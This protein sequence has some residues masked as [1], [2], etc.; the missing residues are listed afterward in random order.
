MPDNKMLSPAQKRK[1]KNM[2]PNNWSDIKIFIKH[3]DIRERTY[4]SLNYGTIEIHGIRDNKP[5]RAIISA[6]VDGRS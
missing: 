2:T 6:Q 3:E 1:V 4:K 5:V